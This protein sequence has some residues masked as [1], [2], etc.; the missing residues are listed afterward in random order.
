MNN[1]Q[2]RGPV[3]WPKTKKVNAVNAST[4]HNQMNAGHGRRACREIDPLWL[5]HDKAWP[6]GS[7]QPG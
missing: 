7:D 6:T 5:P 1:D 2:Q 4:I 3:A